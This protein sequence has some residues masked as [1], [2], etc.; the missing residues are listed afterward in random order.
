MDK[1]DLI[2]P[3]VRTLTP[4]VP[5]RLI[6]DALESL[7]LKSATKLASNENSLGPSPLALEAMARELPNLNRYGDAGSTK[8]REALAAKF[9]IPADGVTC[10]NGSSE[11]ILTLAH[12][13]LGPGL[14]AVMSK[15]SFT[16]YAKNVRASGADAIEVPLK[17][18]N[19]D[20][21]EIL[22]R[23][24]DD[25]RLI[26]LDNPLNPT[27]A[28]LGP[29]VIRDFVDRLPPNVLLVLDEA[30]ADFARAPR[31][32]PR[33]LLETGKTIILRTFSKL[34]GLAGL[35]VGYA[36][37][38]PFVWEAANKV[39]QPFNL[40]NLAQV[41]ALAALRD[42]EHVRKT[43]EM[44]W[45]GLDYF[46]GEFEKLG[47]APR[48]TESNFLM[49]E[50]GSVP[51]SEFTDRL[52]ETGLIIRSLESFGFGDKVRINAGLPEENAKLVRGVKKLLGK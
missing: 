50:T 19:H 34:Y 24:R 16:L 47:L 46:R 44:T 48:P 14:S 1:I 51:S 30:Y 10:G 41:G 35:R 11:I 15:P 9:G 7:G 36:M 40:N 4:Y 38:P 2:P 29:G 12:T 20:L 13:L 28:F 21:G 27:G 8:L 37:A 26:F 18:F 23:I 32:D 31:P 52:F 17:N 6:S 45:N 22:G 5:G 39:R 42:E 3:R 33:E 25:S 43:L 49:V